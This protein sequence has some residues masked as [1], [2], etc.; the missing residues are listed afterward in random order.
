MASRTMSGALPAL[1]ARHLVPWLIVG[2]LWPSPAIT[3]RKLGNSRAPQGILKVGMSASFTRDVALPLA[4]S[5]REPFQMLMEG[6]TGF[7]NRLEVGIPM[8]VLSEQLMQGK[9]HLAIF[10][11]VEFAWE[12][13]KYPQLR[14]LAVAVN[15]TPG[16][17]AHLVVRKDSGIQAW[18]DLRGKDL[19][20]PLH[21]R[22]HAALY[23]EKRCEK[24]CVMPSKEFFKRI[25][26][27]ISAEEALDDLV[28]GSVSTVALDH[29]AL[30]AYQRRKPG[31]FGELKLL[32]SSEQFPDSVVAYRNG[33]LDQN[34][35][36]RCRTGLLRADKEKIGKFLLAFWGITHFAKVPDDLNESLAAI[37]KK[38]PPSLLPKIRSDKAQVGIRGEVHG[39][40]R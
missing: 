20:I 4:Q 21:T 36:D 33:A 25:I 7:K 11:G 13:Q 24:C 8:D 19:A 10:Q 2:L 39:D 26:R 6:N 12:Q 35:L 40:S 22:D 14:P 16:R 5:T 31:R 32:C 30:R 34:T 3:A 1:C 17:Q 9:L 18:W 27:G 23:V 37:R 15:E 29:V 38:Y 28:E